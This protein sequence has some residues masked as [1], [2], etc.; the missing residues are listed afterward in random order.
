MW[1]AAT[2][3]AATVALVGAVTAAAL[4]SSHGP[5]HGHASVRATKPSAPAQLDITCHAP[6]LGGRAATLVYLPAG[7]RSSSERYPVIYFLHGLPANAG[8]YRNNRFVADAVASGPHPAIV[9]APQGARSEDEDDEYLDVSSTENWPRA[10]SYDLTRCIDTRFRT[11][12]NRD[13]RAIVGLS[14]G[15]YGAA[16]IGLRDLAVFGA[17]ESWSGYFEATDPAGLHKLDLGSR[18]A[19][20]MARVPR[21]PWLRGQLVRHPAFIAFYVG[22][23]DGR[24]LTDNI[25]FAQA[26]R[27]QHIP[28]LF[29]TYPGGHSGALWHGKA[30]EWLGFALARLGG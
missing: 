11:I 12:P 3:G 6:A 5:A 2:I 9:V 25:R 29:H 19:N 24:F 10:I 7:Y 23:Q 14:A 18:E 13:G 17:I 30:R 21:G 28:Y 27:Q 20:E 16:N 22:R 15:G 26:L 8:T 4:S 1:R